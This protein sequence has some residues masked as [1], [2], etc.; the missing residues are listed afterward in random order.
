MMPETEHQSG[1]ER[2]RIMIVEDESDIGAILTTM[3]SGKYEVVWACNGLEALDRL[4][5]Y[6]PDLTIMDLMMPVLNGIDT[7]RA[8]KKDNEFQAMPVLFLTARKD[9]QAVREALM[10][11]GDIY[12]EKPFDPRELMTHLEEMITRNNLVPRPKRYTLEQVQRHFSNPENSSAEQ[13]AVAPPPQ[14]PASRMSLTEQL[15][16]AAAV[17]RARVMVVHDGPAVLESLRSALRKAY[18]VIAVRDA[19]SALEKVAA[20]QPDILLVNA[21]GNS[22]GGLLLAQL[23]RVNRQ[24]RV[25][26]AVMLAENGEC[27]QRDRIEHQGVRC[28]DWKDQ[29]P[30]QVLE[31]LRTIVMDP[32]FQRQRKRLD[33]REILRREEPEEDEL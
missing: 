15:A 13:T 12:L 20:Y 32:K 6:E 26:V 11:G 2:L 23:L 14:Q 9:N 18:E 21:R 22:L 5:W 28:F 24:F 29:Q 4:N 19:E 3:L 7:T 33:Y 1:D 8:I 17:P 25:P 10:A 16:R 30:L 27:E 31:L